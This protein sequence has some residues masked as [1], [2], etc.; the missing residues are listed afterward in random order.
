[1]ILLFIIGRLGLLNP[2]NVDNEKLRK[3]IDLSEIHP[4]EIIQQI[5]SEYC[6]TDERNIEDILTKEKH[7]LYH[8]RIRTESC[9]ECEITCPTFTKLISEKHW[10]A[11]YEKDKCIYSM[12][13]NSHSCPLSLQKCIKTFI[14]KH[15]NTKDLSVSMP[16]VLYIPDMLR[17][18]IN[19]SAIKRFD[20]F[21]KNN[22]HKIYTFMDKR[23]PCTCYEVP[24]E[25]SII[26][27][28]EWEI[29]FEKTNN[30]SCK[31]CTQEC[32]CQY[33]ARRGIQFS[34][35]D[36]TLLCKILHVAGPISILNR[37]GQDAFLNF[38]KWTDDDRPLL[39]ALTELLKVVKDEEFH[40]DL[41]N[42]ISTCKNCDL[43]NTISKQVDAREWVSKHVK[44]E[45][46]CFFYP[47]L[48]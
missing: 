4:A 27:K 14:P 15:V 5:I 20:K 43:D 32:C 35:M 45:R 48:Y 38:L 39:G 18:I 47:L 6:T 2:F 16:L 22:K 26:T 40:R 30:A 1:M 13:S 7:D 25:K 34:K 33:S 3:F 11:L 10:E 36:E 41:L 29:L 17:H 21:L 37:I 19:G 28:K 31:T 9:C 8:K 42:R 44:Y 46:V 23:K 12:L 24:T